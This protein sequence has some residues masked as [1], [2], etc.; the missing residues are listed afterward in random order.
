M[1]KAFK[2]TKFNRYKWI[3]TIVTHY[4]NHLKVGDNINI[5]S[6]YAGLIIKITGN[7]ITIFNKR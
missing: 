7:I 3:S 4:A 1:N 5:G 2:R 6:T